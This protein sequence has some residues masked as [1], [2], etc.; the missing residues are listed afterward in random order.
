[1][2][3]TYVITTAQRGAK[4]NAAFLRS[5]QTY[6]AHNNAELLI[7]PTNG[8]N[9]TSTREKDKEEL[10]LA[11]EKDCTVVVGDYKINNKLYIR[12]FPVK[13]QQM[14]PITSWGRFVQYDKSAIMASPKL[15]LK[16]YANS[17]QDLPKILMSTGAVTE[18]NYKDNSWGMKAKLDHRYAAIVVN[19]ASDVKFH[20][21]QLYAGTNG[22]FYDLGVKYDG[23]NAPVKEQVLALIMGD[24]HV[25]FT[26]PAVLA[27]TYQLMEEVNPRNLIYHDIC[28]TYSVN[29]HHIKDAL[30]QARKARDGK[31]SLEAELQGVGSFLH[32]QVERAPEA[33]HIVVKSNHDEAVVR[34][35]QERRFADDPRNLYFACELVRAAIDD[36]HDP[37]E[38][39]VRKAFGELPSQVKFWPIHKD[40]KVAGWQLACH[41]HKGPNGAKASSRGLES[42]IG[43]GIVGHF[44]SP[45]IFRDLW[46]VGT[47]TYL[48]LEYNRG[49]PSNWLQAHAILSP[50]GKPQLINFI[51]GEYKAQNSDGKVVAI[52]RKAQSTRVKKAA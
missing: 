15:M 49:S 50:N 38:V 39:G 2:T 9:P 33:K 30:L 21:R 29:H 6:C 26:D 32:D 11:F 24:V 40:Y 36:R 23:D 16:C 5:L 52:E 51:D 22:V 14:I 28:D 43:R 13:A 35:L 37:L 8:A 7:L 1:M 46:V 45:E 41:G 17:N 48:D 4:P 27:A 47:S 42:A 25:G 20:Y 34:Y 3:K 10:D 44:H 18:P 19:V 31:D 12:D